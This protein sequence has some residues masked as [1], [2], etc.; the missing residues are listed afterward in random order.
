MLW[1]GGLGLVVRSIYFSEHAGSP[2]FNVPILDEKYYDSLARALADGRSVAEIN[3]GFR[4]LLYA[5]FL[6][7][8]HHLVED[9]ALIA[10]TA[11]QHLLGVVTA[12]LVAS[13]ASY[14]FR[15][16]AAGV[17]AGVLYI[18][19]GPPLYFEGE[20]LITSL[21]T[22]LIT[23]L[24][25]ALHRLR[26]D[27]APVAWITVGLMLALAAEARPSVLIFL[28]AVPIFARVWRSKKWLP[29][30]EWG[31]LARWTRCRLVVWVFAGA[32]VGLIG[33]ALAR[34]PWTEHFH[35]LGGSGGVNFYLGNKQGADGKV[36][37]QDRPVTY[38][39]EY[40]DSVQVFAEEVYREQ[41]GHR[42]SSP[43]QISRYWLGR[44][45]AEIGADPVAWI[46]LMAR[47]M[48]Y[49][50]GN[51]EIPNNKNFAF[52]TEHESR[53]LRILP[54][55]WWWLLAL[56]PL[57]VGLAWTRGDRRFLLWVVLFV[58]SYAAGIL[59]FFVNSRFRLPL[60]PCLAMLASGG[61]L[62][63]WDAARGR[64]WPR[65]AG[66]LT[67]AGVVACASLACALAMPPESYARDFFFRSIAHLEKG[68]LEE[69]EADARR[70]VELDPTDAAAIFQLGSVALARGHHQGAL[71]SF[72][73]AAELL[74]GE[75]RIWNNLGVTL[76]RLKH[77]AEAYP[78]Y[79]RAL[80]L[81]PDYPPALVNAALVELRAGR[82]D[83]AEPKVRRARV[84]GFESAPLLCAVAFVERARGRADLARQA[85]ES[86]EA[87]DAALVRRLV[88]ENQRPW[89]LPE[90]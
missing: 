36:P 82:V 41:A 58:L 13:M 71:E 1:V 15:R 30:R 19:A 33:L 5:F 78:L 55:R 4:P 60:W 61:L 84:Q 46:G 67:V 76:E 34:A 70:G 66:R 43:G 38:G 54:V 57:G 24:L 14:L 88:E 72:E 81:A 10:A 52:M 64:R 18:L 50:V 79:L 9:W 56:A 11:V 17:W 8:F 27:A 29:R 28:L 89:N 53:W 42:P 62:S 22:F 86:A 77:P 87:L 45:M 83:L 23:G 3:P 44:G 6:A 51:R 32:G 39:A 12:L 26:A 31:G 35:L 68:Q 69:A 59:L 21:F 75:P 73:R 63:L 49:L 2:F 85:L 16:P 37:R 25:F 80:G 7:L 74:P 47:K 20:I 90:P 65:L 48:V 40:R